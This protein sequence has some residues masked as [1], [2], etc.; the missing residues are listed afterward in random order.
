MGCPLSA[1][2]Y[3]IQ[4]KSTAMHA[5]ADGLSHLPLPEQTDNTGMSQKTTSV[6]NI[7][8]IEA[9]S[10]TSSEIGK[11]SKKNKVLT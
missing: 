5:N 9:V 11:K 2:Q 8:Q 3:E 4:F 1:D 6:F 7:S 10:I